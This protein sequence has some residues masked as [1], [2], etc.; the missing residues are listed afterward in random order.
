MIQMYVNVMAKFVKN[1][2]LLESTLELYIALG[3]CEQ[4]DMRIKAS[5]LAYLEIKIP[6]DVSLSFDQRIYAATCM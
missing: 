1:V 2:C 3:S 4:G 6:M 5:S